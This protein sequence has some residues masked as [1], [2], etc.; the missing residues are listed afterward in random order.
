MN[1]V[2]PYRRSGNFLNRF[3][4]LLVHQKRTSVSYTNLR[5]EKCC[6]IC[7]R[8][9]F[10]CLVST[11]KSH[12]LK[13]NL[14]AKV[15]LI[16]QWTRGNKGLKKSTQKYEYILHLTQTNRFVVIDIIHVTSYIHSF[17]FFTYPKRM[18]LLVNKS[19]LNLPL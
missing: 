3:Q 10:Q 2:P 4:Q 13:R 18:I 9:T 11:K 17:V 12:I 15:C 1:K 7:V 19:L 6:S 14:L 5:S 8:L 16:F